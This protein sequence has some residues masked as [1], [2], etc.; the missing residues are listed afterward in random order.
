MD[1]LDIVSRYGKL[2]YI[3]SPNDV[4]PDTKHSEQLIKER[5]ATLNRCLEFIDNHFCPQF[6]VTDGDGRP[7]GE[8]T[9]S[10]QVFDSADCNLQ[11]VNDSF[12]KEFKTSRWYEEL[13]NVI[14]SVYGMP[15]DYN[16]YHTTA[17]KCNSILSSFIVSRFGNLSCAK[18]FYKKIY[19]QSFFI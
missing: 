13:I 5:F 7:I 2:R 3:E 1:T 19:K 6:V 17:S 14:S 11:V 15:V 4:V 10:L 9:I 12:V 18:E 8:I 16:T